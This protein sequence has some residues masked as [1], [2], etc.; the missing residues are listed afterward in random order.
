MEKDSA[1]LFKKGGADFFLGKPTEIRHTTQSAI[2]FA[3]L[4]AIKLT[5]SLPSPVK[6][7]ADES[8]PVP[9]SATPDIKAPLA[10]YF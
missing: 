5:L 10:L 7:E 3:F 4:G 1:P 8:A 2:L 9:P 6:G